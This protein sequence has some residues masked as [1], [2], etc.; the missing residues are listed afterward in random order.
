M[1]S[2]HEMPMLRCHMNIPIKTMS[3]STT[4]TSCTTV[5]PRMGD[6]AGKLTFFNNSPL[7]FSCVMDSKTIPENKFQVTMPVNK[8]A[9]NELRS[10]SAPRGGALIRK[11]REKTA[12]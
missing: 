5:A 8:N 4:C 6:H 12:A 2:S 3:S 7:D 10:G 9:A 11:T 1:A